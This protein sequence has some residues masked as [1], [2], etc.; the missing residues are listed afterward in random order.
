VMPER[1][2]IGFL[3]GVVAVL[4]SASLSQM[5]ACDGGANTCD[6]LGLLQTAV[7]ALPEYGDASGTPI[8]YETEHEEEEEEEDEQEDMKNPTTPA[9]F[10][11]QS[12]KAGVGIMSQSEKQEFLAEHNIYRCMHGAPPL[13]WSDAVASNAYYF[14]RNMRSMRHSSSYSLRPP[15]GPAGENL[16]SAS[17]KA[18]AADAV[19][20]WYK[21]VNNCYNSP[22]DIRKGCKNGRG[23]TGHFTAMIW[24]GATT[25]GC[26]RSN[27][28]SGLIVCRYKAGDSLSGATPNMRGYY[29]ANVKSQIK[30]RSQ[31]QGGG[32]TTLS[33]CAPNSKNYC[34]G[35]KPDGSW[36]WLTHDG[37]TNYVKD[38]DGGWACNSYNG[39]SA[40]DYCKNAK[41]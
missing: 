25:L 8:S 27:R 3:F 11:Q 1:F 16:Y 28:N 29:S 9:F 30:S 33:S 18:G 4:G 41:R 22:T 13:Q 5:P 2:V 34:F 39:Y 21:E 19:G 6:N 23:V 40:S 38:G 14:I 32:G 31:C 7:L 17:W 36:C 24:K 37:K 20:N 26:A 15:A 10:Q 12:M 35:Y